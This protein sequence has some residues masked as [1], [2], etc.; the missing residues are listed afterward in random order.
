MDFGVGHGFELPH[1]DIQFM[2]SIIEMFSPLF[3]THPPFSIVAP[4]FRTFMLMQ[5]GGSSL[6]IMGS[7]RMPRRV[8]GCWEKS[9]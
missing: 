4:T 1:M 9:W 7:F 2:L 8:F 6:V 3:L 5:G